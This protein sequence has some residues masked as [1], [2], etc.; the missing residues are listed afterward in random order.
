MSS[1]LPNSNRDP[2]TDAPASEAEQKAVETFT[3]DV[4]AGHRS[5]AASRRKRRAKKTREERKA[6]GSVPLE[7]KE[8]VAAKQDRIKP[9]AA[10]HYSPM[11]LGGRPS[12]A[13]ATAETPV[14]E[15]TRRR[16]S[17][18]WL[19]SLAVHAVIL[20]LLSFFSLASLQQEDFG[21]WAS[22]A[23]QE[24]VD[25]FV[26]IEIDP[27]VEF[28]S[29]DT[30]LPSELEEPGMASFGELSA[31]SELS[32]LT[33]SASLASNNLGEWGSLFG[34]SGSGLS[35]LGAGSGGATT[36]FFGTQAKAGRIVF[37][38]DNTGSMNYGG[39]ETVIVELLK[40]VDAMDPRQQ[41]YVL[42]FSDQVYPLFYPQSQTKFVRPTDRNKQMLR[43]WLN[44]VELCTGGVWQLTQ[45]LNLAYELKPDVVYLLCDGRDWD[46]VRASYKVEA[47][48]LLRT[49]PNP[50]G[51]PVHA[52][53]MG[54]KVD[55]D[56][57]NLA[58]VARVNSGTFRE[59]EV[60]PALVEVA[61]Q[62]NR[63]YHIK[64][65]G[66][67]WGTKVPIRRTPSE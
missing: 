45:S 21:L 64:G 50:L 57:E 39:L 35:D 54:C 56:R 14:Q 12:A 62:R 48:K 24:V 67:V 38:I 23:P 22:T 65:P 26:E 55:A 2:A 60:T 66:E 1:G 5:E 36:S 11:S 49:T 6:A 20:L 8:P 27:S 18:S 51:I 30:E 17:P 58:T 3:I 10:P 52:L 25:E 53:G 7:K 15:P 19:V 9:A 40:S 59:V 37:V 33:S 31:E 42:F 63:P 16:R 41:F 44:T 43:N 4:S 34:D 32:D 28:E 61:R 47:V 29:L 46:R 13:A